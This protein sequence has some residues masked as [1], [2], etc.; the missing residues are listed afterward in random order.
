LRQQ[1]A[2]ECKNL[3]LSSF[4]AELLAL[5]GISEHDFCQRFCIT[6]DQLNTIKSDAAPNDKSVQALLGSVALSLMPKPKDFREDDFV[7]DKLT[8][9]HAI[10][11][12]VSESEDLAD[13]QQIC[14]SVASELVTKAQARL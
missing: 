13:H 3:N 9:A 10:M 1:T 11:L 12:T 7:H 5:S 14:L 6:Q 8:Q 4:I 2:K